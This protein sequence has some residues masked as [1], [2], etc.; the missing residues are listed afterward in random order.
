MKSALVVLSMCLATS[1][2]LAEVP[3]VT[4]TLAASP[5]N[6]TNFGTSV[7][8]T[9]TVTPKRVR[10]LSTSKK[11]PRG[12]GFAASSVRYTF[13][14]QKTWPCQEQPITITSNASAPVYAWSAPKAGYY[15]FTVKA[16]HLT[17]ATVSGQSEP[18]GSALVA[19]YKVKPTTNISGNMKF[20]YSPPSGAA[21]IAVNVSNSIFPAPD[22]ALQLK[23]RWK[24]SC[25]GGCNP[26]QSPVTDTT[27]SYASWMTT[28][29]SPGQKTLQV[30][31][32]KARS[33]DCTWLESGWTHD[34]GFTAQ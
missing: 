29:T 22:P 13:E 12:G 19:N 17:I 34:Y 33:S 16:T 3:A 28:M 11:S 4:V 7:I 23:W 24:F 9:A 31:V 10:D 20:S 1:V 2:V 5:A 6:Q 15:T 25:S 26:G 21:P 8:L 14:A 27:T 18:L 32:D 30:F